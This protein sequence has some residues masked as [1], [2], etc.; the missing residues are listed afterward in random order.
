[1]KSSSISFD[2]S[3]FLWP[4]SLH[5]QIELPRLSW[6]SLSI[7]SPAIRN[8]DHHHVLLPNW[9]VLVRLIP[10]SSLCSALQLSMIAVYIFRYVADPSPA[11]S[12]SLPAASGLRIAHP[13]KSSRTAQLTDCPSMCTPL[14]PSPT[15]N[16][17]RSPWSRRHHPSRSSCETST[18]N[19][20]IEP[21]SISRESFDSY[22]R[23][24]VRPFPFSHSPAA[25]GCTHFR[26]SSRSSRPHNWHL[27]KKGEGGNNE[28]ASLTHGVIGHQRQ[29]PR[30]EPPNPSPP[31]P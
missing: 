2:I 25:C 15:E 21:F 17:D 5:E 28:L 31:K 19:G 8:N 13:S 29:V 4:Y 1:M 23:S 10:P 18:S 11:G 3:F 26:G 20:D 22:R 9:L 24:F 16:S 7:G 14:Q 30:R 12:L 6:R 27:K